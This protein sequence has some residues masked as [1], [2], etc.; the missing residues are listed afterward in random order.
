MID[1]VIP[2]VPA[3]VLW[4]ARCPVP[5]VTGLALRLGKLEE[6]FRPHGI[7][8]RGLREENDPRFRQQSFYHDVKTL[9]REG[10]NYPAL[11][12]R[13]QG[14]DNSVVVGITWIDETQL[15]LARPGS[16][17]A[18]GDLAA[19]KGAVFGVSKAPTGRDI[20]RA[21]ALRGYDTVIK[22][23]GLKVD[24]VTF[25]DLTPTAAPTGEA[26]G[27]TWS[28]VSE[29]ALL[30][31]EVD[32]IY[33]KGA[34]AVALRDK[35]ELA[36][37]LDINTVK[38]PRFRINNG[39][40][41]PITVHK[42]FLNDHPELVVEFLSALL[43]TGEWARSHAGQVAEVVAAETGTTIDHVQAGY[44][45]NLYEDFQ[46]G[47]SDT[48]IDGLQ[49]QSDFLH[50]SGLI[51]S[52]VDVRTWIEPAPLQ[53]ALQRFAYDPQAVPLAA[54]APSV[55]GSQASASN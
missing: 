55:S 21:M 26:A 20:W 43:K 6:A 28:T 45:K 14:L 39:T 30:L 3:D 2:L 34:P 5:T 52:P 16:P 53:T 15:L 51:A 46:V 35:H 11:A 13:A 47:L 33:A 29:Q 31:G 37:V 54:P 10:G 36:V 41:R 22:I 9:V 42:H 18:R 7:A 44:G 40:P 8:V 17:L 48:W 50:R 32:V 49:D 27:G 25:K 24:D 23:A 4:V 38:A 1:R 19:L 12:A